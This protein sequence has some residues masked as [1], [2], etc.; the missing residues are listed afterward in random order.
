MNIGEVAELTGVPAR[1]IRYYEAEG[2]LPAPHRGE[3][4]YRSYGAGDAERLL[5]VKKARL[6]GLSLRE[7]KGILLLHDQQRPTCVHVRSLLDAKLAE[8]D[9]AIAQLQSFKRELEALRGSAGAVEDCRPVGG[10]ICGIIEQT[11]LPEI[12]ASRRQTIISRG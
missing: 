12:A 9:S 10:R 3:N 2:L 6:L 4:G 1:T 11:L 8:V 7:I 5:F